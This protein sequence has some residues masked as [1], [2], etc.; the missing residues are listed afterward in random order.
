[1]EL[2]KYAR[3]EVNL[4]K[5]NLN[6]AA[7]QSIRVRVRMLWTLGV[8]PAEIVLALEEWIKRLQ[9]GGK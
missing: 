2:R 1:M 3:K 5:G 7:W 4:P 9:K 6:R 8:K